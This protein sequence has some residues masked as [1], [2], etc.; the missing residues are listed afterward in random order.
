MRRERWHEVERLYH[1]A[2]EREPELRS[3]FLAETAGDDRELLQEVESLLKATG[4]DSRLDRPVWERSHALRAHLG[5]YHI[6]AL[7]G[8]GGMGEVDRARDPRLKRTV[9]IKVS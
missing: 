9:A 6:E 7:L 8:T 4:T 1:L 3:A 5:P 2:L